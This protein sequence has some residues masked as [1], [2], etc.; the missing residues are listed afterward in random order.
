MAAGLPVVANPVGV[1]ADMIR[2][3][4]NGF[5]AETPAQWAEAVGRLAQDPLL[6]RR[7]GQAGRRRLEAEFSVA[8]GAARWLALLEGLH[9][10][11]A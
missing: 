4:D 9:R 6:R 2:H 8:V 10:R 11:A 1:Q 5:L 7:M 3:G